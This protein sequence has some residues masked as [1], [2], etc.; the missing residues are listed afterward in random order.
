MWMCAWLCAMCTHVYV[1]GMYMYMWVACIGVCVRGCT[2]V[3]VGMGACMRARVGK[4][5]REA[6]RE[7]RGVNGTEASGNS[8]IS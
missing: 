4:G 3:F 8:R 6:S 7:D 2:C 1:G 5:S